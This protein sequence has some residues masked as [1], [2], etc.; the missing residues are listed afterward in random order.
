MIN[1]GVVKQ[2]P[3][4]NY[5]D[6]QIAHDLFILHLM[7]GGYLGSVAWL[8]RPE[9]RASAHYCSN[10]DGSEISQL[11]PFDRK[12]WAECNFNGHGISGEYPGFT[13]QGV[14]DVTLR[15]MARHGA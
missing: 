1:M 2:T 5:S 13:A 3:S 10:A 12:A 7:E 8:C 9:A 14:P 11:V 6:V 15:A 4:A